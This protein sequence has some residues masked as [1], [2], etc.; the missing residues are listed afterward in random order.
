MCYILAK[1]YN[2]ILATGDNKLKKF[3]EE[4]GVEVIRTLKIMVL[5]KESN[6]V[7]ISEFIDACDKLLNDSKTRIPRQEILS[8]K[9]K[10]AIEVLS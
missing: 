10:Y 3:A 7:T 2:G 6:I 1:K 4:N 5:M 9:S 8:L